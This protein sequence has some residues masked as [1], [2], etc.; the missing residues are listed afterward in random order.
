MSSDEIQIE[1]DLFYDNGKSDKTS[2]YSYVNL[3]SLTWDTDHYVVVRTLGTYSSNYYSPIHVST[4]EELSTN[5]ELSCDIKFLDIQGELQTGIEI[6]SNHPQTYIN[7]N[8][9][10]LFQGLSKKGLLL[11][12]NGNNTDYRTN[13]NL[14]ANKYYKFIIQVNGINVTANII[15]IT[16]DSTVYTTT[17]TISQLSTWKKWNIIVGGIAQTIHFK[18]LKIKE[19]L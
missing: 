14:S 9:C 10:I 3:N 2:Q 13:G 7:G 15:D 8:E 6:A 19:L 18:N 5:Y 11:K 1:D 16:D 4:V 12:V 17:Q